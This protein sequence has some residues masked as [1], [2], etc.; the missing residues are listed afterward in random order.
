VKPIDAVRVRL[1]QTIIQT[2]KDVFIG[3][4]YHDGDAVNYIWDLGDGETK[5]RENSK[6]F[7][8]AYKHPGIYLIKVLG[9]ND[10]SNA[11]HSISITVLDGIT[12]LQ[13]LSDIEPM[14]PNTTFRI[15][16]NIAQGIIM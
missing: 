12:G 14:V 8:Y 15:Y 9:Y 1:S 10:I 11:T 13:L 7:N 4:F 3:V 2:G 16:W 5:H 6:V